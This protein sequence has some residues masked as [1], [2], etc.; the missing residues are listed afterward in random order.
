MKLK[1]E[2]EFTGVRID[3]F[4][5]QKCSGFSRGQ[6][7]KL[8]KENK[9]FLNNSLVDSSYRLKEGDEITLPSPEEVRAQEE[10]FFQEQKENFSDIEIIE[11]NSEFVVVNK[12]AGLLSHRAPHIKEFSLAEFLIEKYPE[13]SRV[14]EDAWKP[15]LLHRLD[16]NVSG[17]L[18]AA[19]NQDSF[20]NLKTQFQN[21]EVKKEYTG[22]VFG[23]IKKDEAEINL[24]LRR[25][26][27]G[28]KMSAVSSSSFGEEKLRQASTFFWVVSRK[29]KFTLL[30]IRIFTGRTH[31]IRVHLNALGHP[32][33]GDTVYTNKKA[34]LENQKL[35]KKGLW[36]SRIFLVSDTLAFKDL[37]GET[38]EFRIDIPED[39]SGFY[40]NLN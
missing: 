3:K 37:R 20:H 16:R 29:S 31:Q 25:S 17:L 30:R 32:L 5:S 40:N 34:K 1:V 4:L 36:S 8:I 33:L 21:R 22:L 11:E 7:Q 2:S 39:L 19:R 26:A 27:K 13:M 35:K 6:V 18:V 15:G 23:S 9:V 24:P 12:P 28:F 10:S 38:R 14:G